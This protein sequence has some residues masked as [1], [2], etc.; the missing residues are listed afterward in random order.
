MKFKNYYSL[1]QH[2]A[3]KHSPSERNQLKPGHLTHYSLDPSTVSTSRTPVGHSSFAGSSGF[4]VVDDPWLS[5][6]TVHQSD[7]SNDPDAELL[8]SQSVSGSQASMDS[9]LS[10]NI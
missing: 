9:E 5:S 2:R 3:A 1:N 8:E 10:E 7:L 4:S 6:P